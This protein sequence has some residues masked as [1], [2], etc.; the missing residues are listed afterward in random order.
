ML[1]EADEML[2]IGFAEDLETIFAALPEKRY[3]PL[4]GDDTAE[5]YYK[6]TKHQFIIASISSFRRKKFRKENNRKLSS[7]LTSS[8]VITKLQA[9]GRILDIESP[10]LAIVFARTKRG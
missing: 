4:L 8:D 10:R 3:R 6:I 5:N 2:D 1:D 7:P 9:L